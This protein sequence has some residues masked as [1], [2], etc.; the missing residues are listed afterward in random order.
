MKGILRQDVGALITQ[1]LPVR[2][3]AGLQL[4]RGRLE[5]SVHNAVKWHNCGQ[6]YR[7]LKE[8]GDV[9]L[10]LSVT[11]VRRRARS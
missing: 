5:T 3:L 2:G 1:T 7:P 10:L 4:R 9:N 8:E 6:L 11:L